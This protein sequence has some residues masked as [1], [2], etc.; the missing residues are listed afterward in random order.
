MWKYTTTNWYG[1]IKTSRGYYILSVKASGKK[2]QRWEG[3]SYS[4]VPAH[5]WPMRN[6]NSQ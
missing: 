1:P 5:D 3:L 6:Q 2:I 4:E